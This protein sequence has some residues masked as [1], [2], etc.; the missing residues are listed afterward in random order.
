MTDPNAPGPIADT[1]AEIDVVLFDV[2]GVLVEL[3]GL[4]VFRGWTDGRMT[5][6]EIWGL[7][8]ASPAVRAFERGE[9]EA[10]AFGRAVVAEMALPIAEAH[11]LETFSAWPRGLLPGASALVERLR[12]ELRRATLSN[13]NDLHWPRVLGEMGL[14]ALFGHHF[15]SHETGKIK[16][17]AEAFHQVAEG[18]E[19][20]PERI[21][22]LDDVR[23]NVE[24]AR[25][26]GLRAEQ[27]VGVEAAER[28]LVA[29]DLLV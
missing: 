8:L 26:A 15:P 2:G 22:F 11:F 13:T 10:E 28:V 1:V 3:G 29:A 7:W 12:P 20:A 17:D 19:I 6:D 25:D 16:P 21:L 14:G 5:D 27:A 24:A 9:I 4:D 18:L 23:H